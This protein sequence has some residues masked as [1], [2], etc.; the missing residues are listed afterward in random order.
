MAVLLMSPLAHAD[1][2]PIEPARQIC[3]GQAE[4]AACTID[5]QPG[6][7]HGPHPSRM[8]CTPMK[9]PPTPDSGSGSAAAAGSG[10]AT[11]T[12]PAPVKPAVTSGSGA[13]TVVPATV[14]KPPRKT[15]CAAGGDFSDGNVG[16]TAMLLGLLVTLR[17]RRGARG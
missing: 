3:M 5:G 15:G 13:T 4:G 6:V 9:T 17:R 12:E 10:S 16:L 8:Y 14:S 7:C 1:I 11:A 2:G